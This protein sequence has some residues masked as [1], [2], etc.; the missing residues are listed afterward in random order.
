LATCTKQKQIVSVA[1][2]RRDRSFGTG[3]Q[4]LLRKSSMFSNDI[5]SGTDGFGFVKTMNG[6]KQIGQN[7]FQSLFNQQY[8]RFRSRKRDSMTA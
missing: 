2:P 7:A 5:W 8:E 1:T 6:T 3:K 4:P